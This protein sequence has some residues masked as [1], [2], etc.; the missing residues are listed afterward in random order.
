MKALH[1]ILL[2]VAAYL[3][4][5]TFFIREGADGNTTFGIIVGVI[6]VVI[7]GMLW[8]EYRRSRLVQY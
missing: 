4:Y 8:M 3:A 6:A 1:I 2:L 7:I 5:K